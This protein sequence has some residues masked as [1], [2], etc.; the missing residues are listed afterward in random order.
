M[1]STAT[2]I[3][4]EPTLDERAA[5][6][7]AK[8]LPDIGTAKNAPGLY[9]VVTEKEY[10]VDLYQESCTC[11]DAR[12]RN[13][14]CKHIRRVEMATGER[15]IPVFADADNRLGEFVGDADV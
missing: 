15:D 4:E 12:Y 2:G 6:M 9:T 5:E 11:P 8:V 1:S 7:A 10:L 3:D 13:R 14:T